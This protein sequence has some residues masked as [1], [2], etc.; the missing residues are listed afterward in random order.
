[1][2]A[3]KKY[4]HASPFLETL[5]ATSHLSDVS[6][7]VYMERWKVLM[8]AHQKDVFTIITHPAVYIAWIRTTYESP[9]TQKSYLSAVLAMFR[10]NEGLKEQEKKAYLTWYEAFQEVHNGIDARYKRNEPTAKQTEGYVPFADIVAKRDTLARGSEERLLLSFYTYIP[11]LRCDL[12]A[13]RIYRGTLP[14]APEANYVWL[15]PDGATLKLT[16]FKTSGSM[17]YERALPQELITELETSLER[18]P[19]DYV[20]VDRSG[21]A[22]RASSFTKWA[23]RTLHRLFSKP[24]TVSLI[25]HSYI[26]S[27]DFNTLTV[28]EKEQIAKDMAH[29]LGTQDRYRLLF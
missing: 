16:E 25:R 5:H 11:P 17:K 20:F 15:Q 27:L 13:V 22:Y 23:N 24:L 4:T 12:N 29:T 8:Q 10:H 18:S 26:N 21:N 2:P 19:R 7:R 6:K 9:S 3:K 28:Q 14:E 1:M